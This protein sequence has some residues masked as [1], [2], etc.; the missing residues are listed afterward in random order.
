MQEILEDT[1]M[2]LRPPEI[3]DLEILYLWENDPDNWQVS[4][5]LVPLSKHTLQSYI[6]SSNADI[7]ETKQLRLMIDLKNEGD[8]D[9]TIGC[10]DL[11]DFDP[12]HERA[13]VG[14]LIAYNQHRRKGFAQNALKLLIEYAFKILHLNQLFCNISEDN[15]RSIE[16]FENM[17][18]IYTGRKKNW[19][20]TL[21]GWK[22]EIS[23]QILN[24]GRFSV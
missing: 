3:K 15:Q 18:F 17:N 14:I 12:F 24:P 1:R 11:F 2:K 6:E 20:K 22:D 23:Y 4:N 5:T 21:N 19:Y 7:Y 8:F 10:I 16:L 9:Q 13:G